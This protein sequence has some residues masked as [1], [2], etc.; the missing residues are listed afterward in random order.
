MRNIPLCSSPAHDNSCFFL[1]VFGFADEKKS[2]LFRLVSLITGWKNSL[3]G[4]GYF[5]GAATVGVK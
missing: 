2:S 1:C 4:A 3:K 5:L